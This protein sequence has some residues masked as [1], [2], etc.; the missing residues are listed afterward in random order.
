MRHKRDLNDRPYFTNYLLLREINDFFY[1]L[2]RKNPNV[3]T[4]IVCGQSA[5]GRNITGIKISRR[6]R[7]RAFFLE[8]GMAAADWLSPTTVTYIAD[9]LVNGEDRETRD[10]TNEFDWYLFPVVNPDGFQFTQDSVS[11][12][13]NNIF[14]I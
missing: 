2:E 11:S 14:L 10:A 4:V 13:K 7:R 3:V 1:D 9:Q 12:L 5:E 6:S 8:G